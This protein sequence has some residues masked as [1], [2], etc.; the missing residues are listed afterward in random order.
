MAKARFM[1]MLENYENNKEEIETGPYIRQL[2]LAIS[3]SQVVVLDTKEMFTCRVTWDMLR[4]WDM[5]PES[6]FEHAGAD[7]REYLPPTIESMEDVI[8]GYLVQE[9]F[10][11]TRDNLEEAMEKAE[12][13][14]FK[15]FGITQGEV[16]RVYVISNECR[17]QGSA[18]VF[19]TDV[20]KKLADK[21]A[22]DLILLPSSVH[23]W[24]VIQADQAGPLDELKS[25]VYDAN[26]LVVRECEVLS[27]SVY[28]YSRKN[29]VIEIM[30]ED[31]DKG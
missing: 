1:I 30:E 22:G 12:K 11:N 20:L 31:L 6:L 24:L 2:D 26:R 25:M 4:L 19:Y 13:D 18:V 23:E 14:Y 8:K 9:Y 28:Y 17:I 10:E 5:S 27:D 16:P 29:D 3:C 21:T 15:L 7:S